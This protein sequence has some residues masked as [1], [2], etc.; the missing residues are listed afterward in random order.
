[1]EMRS[2][3]SN[4]IIF[5][6]CPHGRIMEL[7]GLTMQIMQHLSELV[8]SSTGIAWT[9]TERASTKTVRIW[10]VHATSKGTYC[11]NKRRKFVINTRLSSIVVQSMPK[12]LYQLKVHSLISVNRIDCGKDTALIPHINFKLYQCCIPWHI[13]VHQ[14]YQWRPQ[15]TERAC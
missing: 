2:Q 7:M 14:C 13:L 6:W 1:M 5:T 15:T 11:D 8:S 4:T 9:F 12:P 3:I 10:L